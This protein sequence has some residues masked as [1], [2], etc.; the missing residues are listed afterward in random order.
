[1]AKL[2]IQ[3]PCQTEETMLEI[4]TEG[5]D[6]VFSM[7]STDPEEN[8]Y[9]GGQARMPIKQFEQFKDMLEKI[10]SVKQIQE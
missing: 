6:I 9:A 3:I 10:L 4:Y 1:M 2:V 5:D 8:P 7:S